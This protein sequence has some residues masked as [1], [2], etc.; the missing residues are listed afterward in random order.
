[1]PE[2]TVRDLRP[3]DREWERQL[4][5]GHQ[6]GTHEI[7]RLGE[8]LD[9]LDLEG[10]VA[11]LDGRPA[12]VAAVREQ[13]ES[14]LEVVALFAEPRGS[15]AGSA[16]LD[17]AR[18]VAVASG[19]HRLWLVTTNDNLHAIHFYLRRGLRI[20]AVHEGAVARDRAVK[21][22]IAERNAENDLPIRDLV[23]LEL[24]GEDLQG[25]L[26]TREFP[27][28]ED[29]DRLPVEAFVHEARPLFEGGDAFLGR[30]AELRPFET[31]DGFLRAAF[32]A[33]HAMEEADRVALVQAHPPIGADPSTVSAQSYIE[34]GYDAEE[35]EDAAE[36]ER[37]RT[38]LA[39]EE[40]AMLNELYEQRFGFRYVVFVAGRPKAEIVPLLEHALRNDR[41]AELRRAVDDAIYIAGDR[42]RRMRGLGAEL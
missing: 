38:Q 30:L 37:R 39:Y 15:G 14:G 35:A 3:E 25:P 13:A 12:G 5:A 34:Q 33:V 7:A 19:H 23:E 2:V 26:R 4:I 32:E 9:P 36:E 31:E 18:Q 28:V 27:L 21:P 17:T 1:V 20:A 10:L 41:E 16:L 11:E 6:G 42:L 8:K 40:L 22:E 29:L 24:T